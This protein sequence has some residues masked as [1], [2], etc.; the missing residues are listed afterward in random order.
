[1]TWTKD[2]Q[3]M[4]EGGKA[5]LFD[6]L[7]DL[8]YDDC[9]AKAQ[10][11]AG[12]EGSRPAGSQSQS[13]DGDDDF[14]A[15]AK[16]LSRLSASSRRRSSVGAMTQSSLDIAQLTAQ[17]QLDA[18]SLARPRPTPVSDME[19]L[20]SALSCP[21][22]PSNGMYTCSSTSTFCVDIGNNTMDFDGFL[23]QSDSSAKWKITGT[24]TLSGN[25]ATRILEN[26]GT[27]EL[28]GIT[29]RDGYGYVS[30]HSR[31]VDR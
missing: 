21:G 15:K 14:E 13:G 12:V 19:E 5:S 22:S 11:I 31:T 30:P 25:D 23:Y 20:A 29:L 1:M 26:L 7:E 28:D 18:R 16:R 8:D 4:F 10:K 9:L 27:L 3:V 24:G 17:L 2:P 6:L